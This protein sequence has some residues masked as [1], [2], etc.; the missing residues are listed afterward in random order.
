MLPSYLFNIDVLSVKARA[1]V[2][3][4]S[5]SIMDSLTKLCTIEVK[6][7]DGKTTKKFKMFKKVSK[8]EMLIPRHLV[9]GKAELDKIKY[10]KI[11]ISDSIELREDQ[12]DIVNNFFDFYIPNKT[13][14][15][16][17]T[18]KTGS[19][20]TVMAI[21]IISILKLPTLIV[22]PTIH[23]VEQWKDRISAF[24]SI[25]EKD[26][27]IIQGKKFDLTKSISIGVLKSLATIRY[28]KEVYNNFG[29]IV[30]DEGHL[31]GAETFSK[32]AY[33]FNDKFRLMLSATPRRKDGADKVFRYNIGK[34]INKNIS[35]IITPTVKVL[36]SLS[37]D[38]KGCYLYNG[39]FSSSRFLNKL[40]KDKD[41]TK[42]IA[43]ITA[44]YAKMNKRILVLS[45]RKELLKSISQ[46]LCNYDVGWAIGGKKDTN[47][48]I[49]L[50]TYQVAGIGLD[51]PE[52]DTLIF[53]T[54]RTDIEQAVGRIVRKTSK[55]KEPIVIDIVDVK[56]DIM[57]RY[58]YT[59]KR[60]YKG[61]KA[62]IIG[63]V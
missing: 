21:K 17:I 38:D 51:I 25:K 60:F 46:L 36:K 31:L 19:G 8:N 42:G 37:V 62:N 35:D 28:P 54:P 56:S 34:V 52:L 55:K 44:K 30:F 29:L 48:Q 59:R 13:F 40:A 39:K 24:T 33:S 53:A 3:V 43:V 45:D 4:P 5:A 1:L 10:N 7:Y 50:G 58:F 11:S 20:K 15:G 14:G 12:K 41:R 63:G 6:D 18:A 22:V 57:K 61:V 16:I 9:E 26:I 27:G 23:L 47:H 32:V 49:I 2:K